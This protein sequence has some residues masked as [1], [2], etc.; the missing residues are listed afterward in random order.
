[1]DQPEFFSNSSVPAGPEGVGADTDPVCDEGTFV[2][3]HDCLDETFVGLPVR[4]QNAPKDVQHFLLLFGD[5][6]EYL[7]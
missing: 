1:M 6:S 3:Q 2:K 7:M 4:R 5:D